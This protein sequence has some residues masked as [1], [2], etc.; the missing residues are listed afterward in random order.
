MI[1]KFLAIS[2]KLI[3]FAVREFEKASPLYYMWLSQHPNTEKPPAHN[4]QVARQQ[5][6]KKKN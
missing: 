6:M 2:W 5:N 3:I 4:K 1:R